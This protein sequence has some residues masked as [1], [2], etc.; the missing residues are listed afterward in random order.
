MFFARLVIP[1]SLAQTIDQED[2][3]SSRGRAQ[4]ILEKKKPFT[5]LIK[6]EDAVAFR[7]ALNSVLQFVVMAE[8][9]THL[10]SED[11]K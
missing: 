7:A 2:L 8:K 9:T 1:Q 5:L 3:V 4:T 10:S 6:A 11:K